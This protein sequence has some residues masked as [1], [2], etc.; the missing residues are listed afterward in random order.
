[1]AGRRRAFLSVID[2]FWRKYHTFHIITYHIITFRKNDCEKK[3]SIVYIMNIDQKTNST[4]I[5]YE[6]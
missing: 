6:N 2:A 4:I 1:M 3:L 5:T